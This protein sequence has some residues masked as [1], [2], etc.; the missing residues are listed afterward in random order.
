MEEKEKEKKEKWQMIS[1]S[2]IGIQLYWKSLLI[3]VQDQWKNWHVFNGQDK[4]WKPQKT[5]KFM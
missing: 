1:G 4:G 5:N 2:Q 3:F